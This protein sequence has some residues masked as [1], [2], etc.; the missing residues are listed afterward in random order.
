ML[1]GLLYSRMTRRNLPENLNDMLIGMGI[2]IEHS[3]GY[4]H[5]PKLPSDKDR[6]ITFQEARCSLLASVSSL[7][8]PGLWW[9]PKLGQKLG[10]L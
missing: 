1:L 9:T 3:Y 5:T 6:R 2:P 4:D 10:R 8:G 7:A